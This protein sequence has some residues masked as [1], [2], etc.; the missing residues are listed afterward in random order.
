MSFGL[1]P[2]RV[3]PGAPLGKSLSQIPPI[4]PV[5]PTLPIIK[6][7]IVYN[8]AG[9]SLHDIGEVVDSIQGLR[10]TECFQP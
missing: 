1:L 7:F 4:G 8:L 9:N 2:P 6:P 5:L 10:I 3:Q